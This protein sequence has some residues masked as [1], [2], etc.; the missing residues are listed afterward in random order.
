MAMPTLL[1]LFNTT[2]LFIY[3]II[4]HIA[5]SVLGIVLDTWDLSENKRKSL[6]SII[7]Q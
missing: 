4:V 7:L 6:L 1:H 2:S 5:S 3:S